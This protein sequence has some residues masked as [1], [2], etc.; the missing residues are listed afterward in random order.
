MVHFSRAE[1]IVSLNDLQEDSVVFPPYWPESEVNAAIYGN[2][3]V[4]L[5]LETTPFPCV[6]QRDFTLSE[7]SHPNETVE[8]TQFHLLGW[9]DHDV[10]SSRIAVLHLC[11]HLSSEWMSEEVPP[12]IVQC[13]DGFGRSGTFCVCLETIKRLTRDGITDIPNIARKLKE[14]NKYFIENETQFR[15]IFDIAL[16]LVCRQ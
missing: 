2:F 8:V 12:L 15:F 14:K 11:R 16:D 13:S 4:T 9:R 6:I 5:E 3:K 10:P 7:V 1:V